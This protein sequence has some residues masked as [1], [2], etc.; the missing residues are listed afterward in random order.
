MI[1]NNVNNNKSLLIKIRCIAHISRCNKIYNMIKNL[2]KCI[3]TKNKEN[4]IYKSSH[5][6]YLVQL[7]VINGILN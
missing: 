5:R 7:S 4:Q 3:V 2:K 6:N 1:L